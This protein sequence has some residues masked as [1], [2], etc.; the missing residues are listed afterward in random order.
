MVVKLLNSYIYID[1]EI[2]IVKDFDIKI[3]VYRFWYYYFIDF[4]KCIYCCS[5]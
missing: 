5:L 1:D 2:V 4:D 3:V